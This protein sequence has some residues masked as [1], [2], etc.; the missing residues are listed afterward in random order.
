MAEMNGCNRIYL[1]AKSYV[2]PRSAAIVAA[3]VAAPAA[4]AAV[5]AAVAAAVAAAPQKRW[6]SYNKCNSSSIS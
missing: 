6:R 5:P 2:R 3:A 4:P 1:L